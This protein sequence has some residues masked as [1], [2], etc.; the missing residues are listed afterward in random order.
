MYDIVIMLL[1]HPSIHPPRCRACKLHTPSFLTCM[2]ACMHPHRVVVHARKTDHAGFLRIFS[3]HCPTNHTR[4]THQN[5]KKLRY[6]L[7][8][9][10][11]ADTYKS[12]MSLI[13]V[14]ISGFLE[15]RGLGWTG[16]QR[17]GTCTLPDIT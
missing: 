7:C 17:S 16:Y 15:N 1:S 11:N 5:K 2:H 10:E 8:N 6:I 3:A 9:H 4:H 13:V 12:T 14:D